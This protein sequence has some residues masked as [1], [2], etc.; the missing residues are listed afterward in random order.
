MLVNGGVVIDRD[1]LFC[2]R[3]D[4]VSFGDEMRNDAI[5]RL[6]RMRRREAKKGRDEHKPEQLSPTRHRSLISRRRL[7]NNRFGSGWLSHELFQDQKGQEADEEHGTDEGSVRL[8]VRFDEQ[9]LGDEVEQCHEA[10][11]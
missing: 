10:K 7:R 4:A 6:L 8:F 2:A 1:S 11:A 9:L 3:R 5:E